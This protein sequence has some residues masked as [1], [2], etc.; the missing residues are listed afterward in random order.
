[1]HTITIDTKDGEKTAYV[2]GV[3]PL[4][5]E[6]ED[7][8]IFIDHNCR[9]GHCGCCI[10]NLISGDVIHQHSLVPLAQGEILACQC[11]PSSPAVHIS[12]R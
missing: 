3:R 1:M 7:E 4:L 6:L 12:L 10:I 2:Y 5:S 11:T 8:N 9:Q